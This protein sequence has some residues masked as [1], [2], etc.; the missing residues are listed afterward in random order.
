[1]EQE[2]ILKLLEQ[3]LIASCQPV[4]DSSMDAPDIIARMAM[5]CRDGGA[6]A[7]RIEGVENVAETARV[8]DI[9]ITGIV[10]RDLSDSDVRITPFAEDVYALAEAGAQIIAYDATQ[11]PRPVATTE[12]VAAIHASGCIAMADCATLEDGILAAEMGV[13][14]IGTTLSGYTGGPI[15]KE[16]DFQLIHDLASR[17]YKVV[18]E[19]RFNQPELAGEAISAGAYCVTVGSAITRIEH[20]CQWFND[21]ISHAR[22]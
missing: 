22:K 15:P 5:A 16:P 3:K 11:R 20:I 6:A 12:L 9:P 13:E 10:K 18:A 4:D 8:L 1:M 17:G 7:V 14:L 19:G 21:S 2:R